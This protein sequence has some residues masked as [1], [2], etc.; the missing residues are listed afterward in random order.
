MK[1]KFKITI[2]YDGSRY[3]GWQRLANTE[4]T[5]Q[6]KIET[7]L[8]RITGETIEIHGSGRTDAGVHAYGQVAHFETHADL[9]LDKFLF[10]CNEMLPQ[11]IVFKDIEEVPMDFHARFS[12]K[13]KK[14]VYRVWNSPIPSAIERKYTFHV[15]DSLNIEAIKKA[16]SFLIG[17]HDFQS[18]TAMKS[19]KKLTVRRI[20]SIEITKKEEL[21]EFYYHG[22]GF[23]YKMVRIMTGTLIE[24][25]LGKR[26]PEE[27]LEILEQKKRIYAGETVPSQ[28]LFLLHVEY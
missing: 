1:R 4:N 5:L 22:E 11:D 17:E 15:A 3:K 10:T 21:I 19:K 6:Q 7:L 16:A 20:Y 2:E 8:S 26:Q 27:V 28:G 18:F 24:V 14:Y 25:G 12:A 13:G 23:L 9:N